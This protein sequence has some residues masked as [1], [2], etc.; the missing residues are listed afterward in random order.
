MHLILCSDLHRYELLNCN[1]MDMG[2]GRTEW[3]PYQFFYVI[4]AAATAAAVPFTTAVITTSA[5]VAPAS[6]ALTAASLSTS[7]SVAP[8]T[9]ALTVTS[10][11]AFTAS[12]VVD[13]GAGTTVAVITAATE[14]SSVG[15]TFTVRTISGLCILKNNSF[16]GRAGVNGLD[17]FVDQTCWKRG[18]GPDAAGRES[19]NKYD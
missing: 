5:S 19:R 14:R 15:C 8:A 18:A 7:A 9:P 2:V 4:P 3:A 17:A 12:A 1:Y 10:I 6:P 11:H 13:T 16:V